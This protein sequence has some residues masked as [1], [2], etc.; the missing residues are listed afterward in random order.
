MLRA[1]RSTL[2][3]AAGWT[4]V[5]WSAAA[6]WA[7]QGGR[8]AVQRNPMYLAAMHPK[9]QIG[10]IDR[11]QALWYQISLQLGGAAA[12][13][14][15]LIGSSRCTCDDVEGEED[16]VMDIFCRISADLHT[17]LHSL[18]GCWHVDTF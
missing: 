9:R 14:A 10:R 3:Q 12:A 17:W 5:K 7:A 11:E 6:A 1:V 16:Q 15:G 13:V 4:P 2:A 8:A 18:M